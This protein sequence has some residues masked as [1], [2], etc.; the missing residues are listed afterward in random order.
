MKRRCPPLSKDSS[1]PQRVRHEALK[2][3]DKLLLRLCGGEVFIDCCEGA[4][5]DFPDTEIFWLLEGRG[6]AKQPWHDISRQKGCSAMLAIGL[7]GT[8]FYAESEGGQGSPHRVYA[9]G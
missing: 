1:N 9:G 5:Y 7:D 8:R 2:R 4:A 3:P 6:F